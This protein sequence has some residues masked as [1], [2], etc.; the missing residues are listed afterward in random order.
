MPLALIESWTST[1]KRPTTICSKSHQHGGAFLCDGVGLGK[2]FVGLMLIERFVVQ[3]R[4]RV[5]LIVPKAGREPV[6]EKELRNGSAGSWRC[7]QRANGLQPHRFAANELT[8]V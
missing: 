8:R 2:T 4:K 1:K 3:E 5:A 7:V 6:W